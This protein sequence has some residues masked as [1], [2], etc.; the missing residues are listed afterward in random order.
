MSATRRK[1]R[2]TWRTR[3]DWDGRAALRQR[4]LDLLGE[5]SCSLAE[6]R[7]VAEKVAEI[8]CDAPEDGFEVHSYRLSTGPAEWQKVLLLRPT[9]PQRKAKAR[10]GKLPC[11]VVPF[12]EPETSAGLELHSEEH[13]LQRVK[14]ETAK[15]KLRQY[16]LDLVRQGY[17]VL[18]AEAYPF[19]LVPAPAPD[20]SDPGDGFSRWRAAAARL[21]EL[22]PTWTGLGKL[23]H[24]TRC[25]IDLLLQ[26]PDADGSRLAVMGHSLGGK[27][28]FYTGCLDD[29]VAAVVASDFGLPW[30]STNWDDA[31]YLGARRPGAESDLTHDKLLALLAPGAFF[32]IAGE[33]DTEAS[34]QMVEAARPCYDAA[35]G[36]EGSGERLEWVNHATGHSPTLESLDIAYRWLD[37]QLSA[38]EG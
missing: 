14:E 28:A 24:D 20:A 19:N 4:W 5:P 37:R 11:V 12:Y 33:T 26:Q 17:L 13:G 16:G 18:C 25:A 27:M 30:A 34:W 35:C 15:L 23:V 21:K 9:G 38:A 31:W 1:R 3:G 10:D 8:S 22:Y 32:L 29:R 6:F 7:P 2:A 36:P